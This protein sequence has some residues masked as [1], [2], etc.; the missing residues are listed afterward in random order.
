M[1][2]KFHKRVFFERLLFILAIA[3]SSYAHAQK[4]QTQVISGVIK[5]EK[6]ETLPGVSVKVKGS[7]A[8]AVS[9]IDGHYEIKAASGAVLVFKF[10]GFE[11]KEI[12]IGNATT[13]NV[14][15][16]LSN[17]D[18]NEV[19]VVGYGVQK[20]SDVTGAVTS[21]SKDR[22]D[23]FVRTDVL[24][25]IQ[26]AAAGLNVSATAA[27]ADPESGAVMLIRGRSSIS[28]SND[29]LV[30][31]DGIAF[32]GS[33]SDINPNEIE[34]IEI[35]KDASS[36]AIYGSRASNGV[37][38][39]QT[40]KGTKGKATIRYNTLF[41]LQDV[42]NF[43]QLMNGEEYYNFRK[44]TLNTGVDDDPAITQSEMDVYNAGS[45]KNW[46][47]KDLILK[48]GNSQQHN[49]SISGGSDKT[50]YSASLSYL[51]TN[52]IVI[53]D[54]YKR[55][56]AR[57]NITSN[58]KD[59]LTIGSS[60]MMGKIN[61]SG[62]SPSYVD[63]FN[64][65]PLAV[66][67]NPDGSINITPIADDPR[68]INP[69]ENLLYDDLKE[70]YTASTNNYV[71]VSLPG[72][73]GLSY[74]LN[75]GI[76][77]ESSEKN[78]YR[79]TN[80]GKSGA[81]M[82]ES[83][84]NDG[85]K[86]SYT[87]ENV[88]SFQRE[89]KKHTIFLT[90]LYSFEGKENKI[91]TLTGQGFANDF[92]SYYGITQASKIVPSYSYLKTSLISQMFRANYSY[93]SR[94]LFTWTIR[95]DGFSGFGENRKFGVF[96]S[97]ALGWNIMNEKFFA[98][99]KKTV[100]NLKLRFSY[101]E[102]GNQ[103]INPYQTLSQ[104]GGGDYIDGTTTAPGYLPETLGTSNLG[105]ETTRALNVGLD[106]GLFNSRITGEINAYRNKTT[107]LL[108]KRAI[109]AVHGVNSV[110]QNIG[111][112]KN[113]GIEFMVNSNNLTKKSFSWST[114]LNFAFIK[115]QILDLY[116]DGKDDIANG[117][118]IGQPIKMNFDYKFI[119]VWQLDEAVEAAKYGA[120]P[121]YAKY[122][123]KN[124]NGV[125]DPGDRQ[126]LGDQ[127]PNFNWGLTNNFRYKQIGLSVFMYGKIG[128]TKLNPYK[129]RNY[130]IVR[131]F[132]SPEN[133]INDFWSNNNQA[134]RYLGKGIIPSVYEHADFIRIK[135]I[136]LS[137]T[138][139]R[140]LLDRAKINN[141]EVFFTGKNLFTI[142]NWGA[143]DPELDA[144][145]AVPLQREY[146]LGLKLGF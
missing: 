14:N 145:R 98:A 30:I 138:F 36:T 40:K 94:Y 122:E 78:W 72:I 120:K 53:N 117:W 107:D 44:N 1:K 56:N 27:G 134:T 121:G 61:N 62:A 137:Y 106:F 144:Q 39:I 97:V 47:W 68:K 60:N 110:F 102:N 48:S 23:N 15:L 119:G 116:G 19:V 125:Y 8:G 93:D 50:S 46:T 52:G 21:I 54:Q 66:P 25:I 10:L 99:A 34:S 141:L 90:G 9:N 77:Y 28:A 133:P 136:T 95:R 124:G 96:S 83:Q 49:L 129:D 55:G 69:I 87:I 73:K 16:A 43:P 143:L 82:G 142:S 81:F 42:A 79:G 131:E 128:A 130:L 80:T 70:R 105:W 140:K 127:E 45:W 63:L 92:L 112:T 111:K 115:T 18:L 13:I 101:G 113:E 51:G 32:N 126:L 76:Q 24:Q 33:L 132:W 20:K 103:A 84:T 29:P 89:F 118:F 74:R 123:D 22:I 11:D 71:N 85:Q 109:S 4:P 64:K 57:I 12:T 88:L 146:M 114:N 59:W 58:I 38:L 67:F 86:F 108:L 100:N 17:K 5:D 41:A 37:I 65:S 139:S 104:L 6:G 2:F 26:G 35:L 91:S 75:T 7:S 135:D 3:I 31:L